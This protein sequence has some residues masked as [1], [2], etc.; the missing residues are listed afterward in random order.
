VTLGRGIRLALDEAAAP[1]V[2]NTPRDDGDGDHEPR[3][4][5]R[6]LEEAGWRGVDPGAGT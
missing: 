3:D 6:G 1:I 5:E 4:D 2:G